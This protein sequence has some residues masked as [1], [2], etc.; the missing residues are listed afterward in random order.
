MNDEEA[1]NL[2]KRADAEF[3]ALERRMA[4]FR[5][6]RSTSMFTK[7]E[8]KAWSKA[9]PDFHKPIIKSG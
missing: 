2:M 7:D 8:K 3:R 6:S 9:E 1:Q 4:K 5:K